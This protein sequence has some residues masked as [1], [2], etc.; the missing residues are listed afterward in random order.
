ME[1]SAYEGL[2]KKGG[3]VYTPRERICWVVGRSCLA[4]DILGPLLHL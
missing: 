2:K 1:S 3:F 4:S